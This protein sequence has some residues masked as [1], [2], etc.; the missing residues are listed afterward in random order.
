VKYT[1]KEIK[2][3]IGGEAL[4][5]ADPDAPISHLLL[6]S[7]KLLFPRESVFFALQGT[8]LDGHTYM[9]ELYAKG[10]RNFIVSKSVDIL[11]Y[12]RANIIKVDDV[13]RSLQKLAT[14]HRKRF[15]VPV[16]GITGSNG[17]TIIK[18]WLYQL[19]H[20]DYNIVRS[21]KSYNS[22]IGVPLSIWQ[23]EPEHNLAIFEA[24]IS[25]P[26]E[27]E[28]LE[29]II[30]PSIGI[31]TNIGEAHSEGFLNILHKVREKLRLFIHTDILIYCKDYPDINLAVA[32]VKASLKQGDDHSDK[33]KTF[34]WS[35]QTDADLRIL[36]AEKEDGQT[37]IALSFK[38]EELV[39]NIPF[40][41]KAS[42]ENVIHCIALMLYLG[43]DQKVIQE[44]ILALSG[45]TM[46]LEL[47]KGINNCSVIND[48]YNSD[49]NSLNI[50]IDFLMQQSQHKRKTIILSDILQSGKSEVDLYNEIAAIIQEKKIHRFIGIGQALLRSKKRLENIKNLDAKFYASTQEFL[51]DF[52]PD[53]F[54]DEDILLKGARPFKF[55]RIGRLLEQKAHETV[56]EINLKAILH[57][58]KTY[59]ARLKPETKIM[60]MVKAFAYGAGAYEIANLLQFNRVDYLGVAY[61]DEGADLRKAGIT[62]PIMVMTSDNSGFESIISHELEPEIYS[63][64]QLQKFIQVLR[65]MSPEAKSELFPIHIK[66]D[67]GMHRLGFTEADLKEM[68]AVIKNSELI[69]VASIFSHLAASDAAEHDGFTKL[70]IERFKSMSDQVIQQLQYPVIRHIVNSA[71]ILRHADAHFDMIRLGLGIYGIDGAS[72]LQDELQSVGTLKTTISQIKEIPAGETIGYNRI[73]KATEAKTIA[74]VGIGYADGYDRRFSNGVGHML[75]HGQAAP[76]IGNVCMD[77]TMIDITGIPAQEGDEVIV[78]NA[79][80]P[81][82]TLSSMIGTIPYE[83]LTGI[84]AR[85]KRVYFEE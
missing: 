80:L 62:L 37:R 75:V 41:D 28:K 54:R 23:M 56:L 85:V 29:H 30:Q 60:V 36:R 48:S 71:G 77:M 25:Q 8:R 20:D 74:T 1:I 15:H 61:A 33:F 42:V 46:R 3:I 68:V 53:F 18:E 35:R 83:I 47:K 24:G 7:R 82:S 76:V 40:T 72:Q 43:K 13:T 55:E 49:M 6:D 79:A 12:K 50:A 4:A 34:T 16:I 67:T 65:N 27:M 17:K 5:M 19:L 32:Q 59:Q 52:D 81:I 10:I 58:L 11:D 84:S 31:F 26:D 57:N 21:P 69:R 64:H 39:F 78:F 73:G 70:Q 66:L 38:E 9:D 51:N 63:L 14:F 45:V 44:R 22:Q 2:D